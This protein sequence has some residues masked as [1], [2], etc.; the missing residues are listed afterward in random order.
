MEY[1]F[2]YILPCGAEWGGGVP[3]PLAETLPY[4]SAAATGYPS[5]MD[6]LRPTRI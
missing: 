4:Q 5:S 3:P 6:I 1:I 2:L